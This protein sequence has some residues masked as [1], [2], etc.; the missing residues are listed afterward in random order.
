M[1]E[2]LGYVGYILGYEKALYRGYAETMEN[3]METTNMSVSTSGYWAEEYPTSS[4][5]PKP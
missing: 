2:V 1:H 5:I 4:T 3:Q